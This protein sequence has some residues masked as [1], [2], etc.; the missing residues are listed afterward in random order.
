LFLIIKFNMGKAQIDN[1]EVL[2]DEFHKLYEFIAVRG[3]GA[4]ATVVE[5]IDLE[6]KE[7]IA[8]KV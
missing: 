3:S 2:S 8:V 6:T 1:S 4:F 5:V 7:H